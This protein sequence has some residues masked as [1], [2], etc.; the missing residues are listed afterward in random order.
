MKLTPYILLALAMVGIGDTMFLSYYAYLHIVPTCALKGCEIVLASVYSH[1]F[2]VPFAYIGLLYYLHVLGLA[3]LASIFPNSK[4]VAFA[5]LVYSGVGLLLS[6]GFELFQ[7]FVIG[8]LCMYCA[9]SATTTLLLFA[10]SLW[11]WR[12]TRVSTPVA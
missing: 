5:A 11:H 8:A 2:G 4:A 10:T 9:I 12:T 6:I 7:V 1:P 3:L